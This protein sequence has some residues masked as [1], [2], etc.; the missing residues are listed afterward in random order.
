MIDG[1][2]FGILPHFRLIPLNNTKRYYKKISKWALVVVDSKSNDITDS[3]KTE[4]ESAI[5]FLESR[6]FKLEQSDE[7]FEVRITHRSVG[8]GLN[9]IFVESDELEAVRKLG[10][11]VKV[12]YSEEVL[13]LKTSRNE[14]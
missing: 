12:V 1:L 6:G 13:I 2:P 11:L 4:K 7:G 9:E 14:I 5:E 8:G 10:N 3:K